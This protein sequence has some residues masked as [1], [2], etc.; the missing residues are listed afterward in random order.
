[1]QQAT[2]ATG[3]PVTMA[4]R[5][6]VAA[7]HYL[8]AEAGVWALQQGGN[9]ID[10]AIA[11]AAVLCVVQP[12]MAGLGGDALLMVWRPAGGP[13]IC[14]NGSGAS[15]SE[16]T[17]RFYHDRGHDTVP[18]RGPLSVSTVPGAVAAWGDVHARWGT[19][20][21]AQLFEPAGHY[22]ESGFP[23]S[24]DLARWL[25]QEQALLARS[26]EA[27]A[28]FLPG[29]AP[30]AAGETLVQR[31]LAESIETLACDGPEA[32]YTGDLAAA[33][34]QA[35][36]ARGGLLTLEDLA[37]HH[38]DWLAPLSCRY[39]GHTLYEFPP[40][41][42]GASAIL[43]MS[44]LDGWDVAAM[45]DHS[46]AYYHC[47]AEAAKLVHADMDGRLAD[48]RFVSAPLAELLSQ[49]Y[50]DGRRELVPHDCARP[51][52]EYASGLP[53][54][55]ALCPRPLS[56]GATACVTAADSSGLSVSLV[57]SLH[58]P[59]GSG[60]VAG[61]TG[62]LL[63]NAGAA[64]ALDPA[65]PGRLEPGKRPPVALM[66][67]MASEG[68]QPWLVFGTTGGLPQAQFHASLLTRLIDLGYNVQ[69]AIEAPRWRYDPVGG[70]GMG[71][72]SVEGRLPDSV[73][74]GLHERGHEV[75]A[76]GDWSELMGEAQCIVVDVEHGTLHG[77]ADPR[78]EGQAIGW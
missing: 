68:E 4:A 37:D 58:A 11:A 38:S 69:Q 60:V 52:A 43:M 20:D 8:A 26:E 33:L 10:A 41:S 64:F 75:R 17:I 66:P 70:A 12:H 45:G 54:Q 29:G 72:L 47:M 50:V 32:L 78:G 23:V 65:S 5:G 13:P 2:I 22:A 18:A 44:L 31:Q 14:L 51:L 59:F 24:A 61:D 49:A 15:S 28:I 63:H 46:P 3:R 67:A 55:E 74:R 7:P 62:I 73:L 6:I 40:N 16:A 19:L 21:W 48:P 30:P 35:L 36:A 53:S 42:Q 56:L 27:Q 25:T 76:V 39:R 77:G 34:V 1:M 57:Q 9:A 71:T